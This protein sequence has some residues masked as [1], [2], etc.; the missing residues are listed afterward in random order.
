VG[1]WNLG[2]V[3]RFE[4]GDVEGV[5]SRRNLVVHNNDWLGLIQT[6]PTLH[7]SSTS[8]ASRRSGSPWRRAGSTARW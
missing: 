8:P 1:E 6:T 7:L 5:G 3:D 2:S 4:V